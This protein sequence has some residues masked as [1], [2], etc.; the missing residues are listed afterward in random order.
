MSALIDIGVD[1]CRCTILYKQRLFS[2]VLSVYGVATIRHEF[3]KCLC[4]NEDSV[5]HLGAFVRMSSC[6][7]YSTC[8]VCTNRYKS[9]SEVECR[10]LTFVTWS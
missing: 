7:F 5:I 8:V 9:L 10:S 2:G 1:L 3:C 6:F 4:R